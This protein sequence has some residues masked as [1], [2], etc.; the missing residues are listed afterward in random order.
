MKGTGHKTSG[1]HGAMMISILLYPIIINAVID[2]TDSMITST[3]TTGTTL[4]PPPKKP[5][6]PDGYCATRRLKKSK[7]D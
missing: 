5:L 2:P 1:C 4:P 7:R 6:S 3:V